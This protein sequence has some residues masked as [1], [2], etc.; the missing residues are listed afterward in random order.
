[1]WTDSRYHLQAER[2]VKKKFWTVMR[3]GQKDTPTKDEYLIRE[4]PPHSQVATDPFLISYMEYERLSKMLQSNGHRLIML[5]RNLV[6]IV[7]NNR[8]TPVWAPVWP[9]GLE[10][11]GKKAQSK[12]T[13]IR[14]EMMKNKAD[15]MIIS[16]LD[17][18]A[19]L[20]NLRGYDIPHNPVFF[21]YLILTQ[22]E[23]L[24]F[25]QAER[26]NGTIMGHF[27]HENVSVQVEEYDQI[28]GGLDDFVSIITVKI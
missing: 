26:I 25:T 3:E 6:D 16:A 18:I 4:L 22:S 1:L 21:A 28:L 20:L 24:L 19:W 7:W 10:F 2:Q 5:E 13:E 23:I 27:R 8:P 17:E 12:V 15:S 9:L 11:S 14:E